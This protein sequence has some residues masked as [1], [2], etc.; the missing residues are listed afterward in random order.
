MEKDN[1]RKVPSR[2]FIKPQIAYDR[3]PGLQDATL[4]PD[5]MTGE[6]PNTK[7]TQLPRPTR[8]PNT[9]QEVLKDFSTPILSKVSRILKLPLEFHE[10]QTFFY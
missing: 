1:L 5:T 6:A 8:P 2:I 10:T 3:V 9:V 7:K 4:L